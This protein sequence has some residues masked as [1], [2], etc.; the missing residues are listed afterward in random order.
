M[1][2]RYLCFGNHNFTA[3]GFY[4]IQHELYIRILNKVNQLPTLSVGRFIK[5]A[6]IAN[7]AANIHRILNREHPRICNWGKSM[8]II[9][10]PKIVH[11]GKIL[12][13]G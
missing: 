11:I 3:G 1:F 13:R 9:L 4:F 2:R 5:I 6:A 8:G 7:C 10:I 12:G